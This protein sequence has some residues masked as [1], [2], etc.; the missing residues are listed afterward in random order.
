MVCTFKLFAFDCFNLRWEMSFGDVPPQNGSQVYI[1]YHR[2]RRQQ[3]QQQH[4]QHNHSATIHQQSLYPERS[5]K[6]PKAF[7]KNRTSSNIVNIH[8]ISIFAVFCGYLLPFLPST[9][10]KASRTWAPS[11]RGSRK[12]ESYKV[13][14]RGGKW[15]ARI[16]GMDSEFGY[17]DVFGFWCLFSVGE[18]KDRKLDQWE[19]MEAKIGTCELE[20]LDCFYKIHCYCFFGGWC[21]ST[22][23]LPFFTM[24]S[25]MLSMLLNVEGSVRSPLQGVEARRATFVDRSPESWEWQR[26]RVKEERVL[27]ATKHGFWFTTTWKT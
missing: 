2:R 24:L 23:F 13:P 16:G 5:Q 21:F 10:I 4:H 25:Y 17:M 14:K 12:H 1:L 26:M 18:W 20:Y 11:M 15:E 8:T 19:N 6:I 22:R 3:Q 9:L 27:I 7:N